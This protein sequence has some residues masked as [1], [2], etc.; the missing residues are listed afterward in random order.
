MSL[1]LL[2]SGPAL[3]HKVSVFA[4]VEGDQVFGESKFSGGKRPKDAQVIVRD[5]QG[6]ELLRTRTDANGEF[7]FTI[8]K[9]CAMQIELLAGM[10]H[11]AEWTVPM[12][13]L[14]EAASGSGNGQ[15][16]TPAQA[17]V[18]REEPGDVVAGAGPCLSEAQL[19]SIVETAVEKALGHK[20]KPVM[21]AMAD[22][23][24]K[25]PSVTDV[26]GG[27]GYIFGLTGVAAY[28][29]SRRKRD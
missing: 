11:K 14:E 17:T 16:A 25:G 23:E 19:E 21:K 15:A 12:E 18:P 9:R 20:L 3:A 8:P 28:F 27:L 2:L 26:M 6:N 22:L 7:S 10:G 5:A 4:W 1:V 13:E 24:E 29:M